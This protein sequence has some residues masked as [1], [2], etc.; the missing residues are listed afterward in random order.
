MAGSTSRSGAWPRP[1]RLIGGFLLAAA[2]VLGCVHELGDRIV[3]PLLPVYANAIS[4]LDDRFTVD[5]A[6]LSREGTGEILRFRVNLARPLL[7]GAQE[8]DPFGWG[9]RPAGGFQ[10]TYTVG[11]TLQFDA[12]LLIVALAWPARGARE[13]GWRLGIAA[14]LGAILLLL[15]IPITVVAELRNF[16]ATVADPNG[17]SGWMVASRFLMGGGGMVLALIAALL[18]ILAGQRLSDSGQVP[19]SET[20]RP[21]RA[22]R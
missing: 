8:W 4:L 9:R 19:V 7:V 3:E 16:L 15:D 21:A 6:R 12:L 17:V 5:D 1:Y 22:S 2:L 13:L 14:P 20:S 18:S 11:G 10:I